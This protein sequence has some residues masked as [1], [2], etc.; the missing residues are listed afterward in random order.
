MRVYVDFIIGM[1]NEIED[2]VRETSSFIKKLIKKNVKIHMHF[3]YL[4]L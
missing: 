4:Y 3:L 1:P 2:D